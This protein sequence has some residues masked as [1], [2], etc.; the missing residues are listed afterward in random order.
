VPVTNTVLNSTAI[1]T[2]ETMAAGVTVDF[3]DNT[4][5]AFA[6]FI[7]ITFS[8][9]DQHRMMMPTRQVPVETNIYD[10]STTD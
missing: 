3:Y 6:H 4:K 2:I 10:T 1:E 8:A 5:I 9:G 7:F